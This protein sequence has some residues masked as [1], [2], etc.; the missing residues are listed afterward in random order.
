MRSLKEDQAALRTAEA[1]PR[2][3][4]ELWNEVLLSYW[5]CQRLPIW[6]L[7]KW[8]SG[9]LA[10]EDSDLVQRHLD[11]CETCRAYLKGRVQARLR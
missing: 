11:A 6:K 4:N 8:H 10:A 1:E 3:R 9:E 7:D 5:P 2:S